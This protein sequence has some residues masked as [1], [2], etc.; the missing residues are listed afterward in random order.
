M[1]NFT[2]PEILQFQDQIRRFEPTDRAHADLFNEVVQALLN[3]EVYL[4][5]TVSAAQ[6]VAVMISQIDI[7]IPTYGWV[8]DTDT[9][10]AYA[11]FVDVPSES[12]KEAMIPLL[13]ILPSGEQAARECDMSNTVRT[14]DGALRV[15]AQK[16][17][18]AEI[19]CSLTLISIGG[20]AG[21]DGAGAGS[22]ILPVASAD[23]LGGV[24]IGEGVDVEHD[25]TISVD[26]NAIADT[27]TGK[28]AATPEEVRKMLEEVYS[29]ESNTN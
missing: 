19:P 11:L 27:V 2:I 24:K 14:I 26:S 10:G 9:A 23:R 20:V 12:I 5:R 8:A 21:G 1:A 29:N 22:Y 13:T 6:E 25:G 15:Y 18:A 16:A 17:P 7:T 4:H 28:V 3:N